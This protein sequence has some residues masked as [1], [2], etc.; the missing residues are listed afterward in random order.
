MKTKQQ[1]IEDG[2]QAKRLLT[3]TDL[4]RFLA[5]IEAN[6]WDEFKMTEPGDTSGREAIYLKLR[7]VQ[8]VEQSLR[9]MVDS[10]TIEKRKT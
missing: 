8:F 6:C 5:E 4:T 3:D 1:V 7:G 10:A 2:E 9:A